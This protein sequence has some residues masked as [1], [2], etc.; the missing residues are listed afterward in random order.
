VLKN[1]CNWS[2]RH[3]HFSTTFQLYILNHISIHSYQQGEE[4]GE[5][6]LNM[7]TNTE[8]TWSYQSPRLGI[9]PQDMDT[10]KNQAR[11]LKYFQGI[12]YGPCIVFAILIT[13]KHNHTSVN[14]KIITRRISSWS[15]D[16]G[17]VYKIEI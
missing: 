15:Q 9:G 7:S 16:T 8:E 2:P 6:L 4:D 17:I 5:I 10:S 14:Y 11:H 12:K 3:R 13:K 1:K